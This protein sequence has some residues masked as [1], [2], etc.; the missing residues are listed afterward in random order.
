MALSESFDVWARV[1]SSAVGENRPLSLWEAV[2]PSGVELPSL[3]G[4]T[5]TDVLVIGAGFTG[6]AAALKLRQ[7]GVE[8]TVIESQ[9][10]GAG[11]SGRNSGLVIPTLARRDPDDI[12]DKYGANG[13]RFVVLLRDCADRLFETANALRLNGQAEQ[14]G[15]LQPA[16]TPGR[17]ALIERR[18]AQW[19]RWGAKMEVLDRDQTSRA[20]GTTAW[21]GGLLSRSGGIVNP[22]ALVRAMTRALLSA[23][24]R[25]YARTPALSIDR[26]PDCWTVMTPFGVAQAKGLIVATNAYTDA[27]TRTLLPQLAREIVP[28]TSWLAATAP[29]SEAVRRSVIP[30]RLAMSDTRGDLRFARY[31]ADHR[32]ISGGA[33]INP[34]GR[35]SRLKAL[36]SKRLESMWPQTRG[37]RIEFAWNGLIGMTL[38]RFPRFHQIGPNAFAWSGCNGRAVALSL[39]VGSE[40]AKACLGTPLGEIALPWST[41]APLR[42]QALMRWLAPLALLQYRRSDAREYQSSCERHPYR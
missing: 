3:R 12:V 1:P 20:L 19:A 2:T 16:H 40:L 17:M 28:V 41:P 27:F 29:L 7:D 18:A 5:K 35:L 13:E 24:G 32:L 23:G 38:D 34:I 6:L 8:V 4:P 37:L 15:W 22:L 26:G 11:A 10:P 9:Q 42:G 30:A 21:F 25:I 36:V 31:D 39:A 33:L 14:T